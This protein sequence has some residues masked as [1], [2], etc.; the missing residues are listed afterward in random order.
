[1]W[2]VC[3]YRVLMYS[4]DRWCWK[5]LLCCIQ[6]LWTVAAVETSVCTSYLWLW[7]SSEGQNSRSTD[8]R[9]VTSNDQV[10]TILN[11][12]LLHNS[13]PPVTFVLLLCFCHW[14]PSVLETFYF[15]ESESVHPQNR[16]NAV[17]QKPMERISPSFGHRC[18][19][20]H[21]C[22]D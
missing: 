3:N 13:I 20:V 15:H 17:S 2:S 19:W 22:A 9:N 7:S 11:E 12:W 8:G 4:V 18:I 5:Q 21:R 16:V 6:F 10:W 14:K 1:M